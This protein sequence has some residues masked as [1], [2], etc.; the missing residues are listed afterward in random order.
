MGGPASTEDSAMGQLV[1]IKFRR[2]PKA[3][4]DGGARLTIAGSICIARL[5]EHAIQRKIY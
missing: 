5:R 1:V 3:L 2:M 4:I